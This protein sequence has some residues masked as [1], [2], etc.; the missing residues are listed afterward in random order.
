MQ[1]TCNE[2]EDVTENL[3]RYVTELND[4][5]CIKTSYVRFF[6]TLMGI[7]YVFVALSLGK[8]GIRD[9]TGIRLC[10]FSMRSRLLLLLVKHSYPPPCC[11]LFMQ[12]TNAKNS[13]RAD[14]SYT[15]VA[16]GVTKKGDVCT[17][18]G[19]DENENGV[20]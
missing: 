5:S 3:P 8:L 17:H 15:F 4:F 1:Y 6:I 14:V 19:Y 10:L 11:L 18:V 16:Q 7:S 13:P 9:E 20:L 12:Q 2:S